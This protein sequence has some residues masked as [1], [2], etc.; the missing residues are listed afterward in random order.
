MR[1]DYQNGM[2]KLITPAGANPG[3]TALAASAGDSALAFVEAQFPQRL[4]PTIAAAITSDDDP[5]GRQFLPDA[6]EAEIRPWETDD[7]IGDSAHSPVEGIVHRYPDRALLKLTT[8]CPVHCRFCFRK[9]MIG[10]ASAGQLPRDALDEAFGYLARTPEI[11]EVIIT[12]G[13][14]L[15]LS[16]RRIREVTQRLDAIAHIKVIRWHS[17][18]PVVSPETVTSEF[19]EAL[20]ATD[21]T[22][23]VAVHTNH[24]REHTAEVAAA[25]KRLRQ[26]GVILVGQSVL[27][28]DI[29]DN[30]KALSELMR[31]C[32]VLGIKPYYL[33]L[34][35]RAPGTSHF[36][37]SLSRA[38][39][40]V[41]ALRGHLSGLCQPS[42]ML[43][44][45]GGHGK[46]AIPVSGV[47]DL[48]AGR[49]RVRDFNGRDHDFLDPA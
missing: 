47:V 49:Y 10:P 2:N 40:L 36:R 21:K 43:D 11:W 27:L 44:L 42:L 30:V 45:P 19:V 13:D 31:S 14:P 17:R 38:V 12:G 8:T 35:D 1:A 37:V 16:P 26:A 9:A 6:R 28:K 18:V 3:E 4:T 29:N 46:V 15:A 25:C 22:V 7:P 41:A 20:T 33:H 32:V 34:L 5:L 48:G 24:A 23:Y 39:E